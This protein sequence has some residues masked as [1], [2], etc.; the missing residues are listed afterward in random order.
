MASRHHNVLV[1]L[2]CYYFDLFDEAVNVLQVLV[3]ART[4][5][6]LRCPYKVFDQCMLDISDVVL[7]QQQTPYHVID[8]TVDHLPY[9][10][11]FNQHIVSLSITDH[12]RAT[13]NGD[14]DE[15]LRLTTLSVI[16]N[17]RIL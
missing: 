4:V 15:L 12:R 2:G 3:H 17:P 1:V 13:A 7:C 14:N 11:I 6:L 9:R 10:I 8:I 16:F 5:S